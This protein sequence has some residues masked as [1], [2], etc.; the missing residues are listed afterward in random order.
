MKE[1]NNKRRITLR[2]FIIENKN[3]KN[4]TS[5]LQR[6]FKEK[7]DGSLVENRRMR[8]NSDD[9]KQ[10]EDILALYDVKSKNHTHGIM[11]R[12]IP[13]NGTQNIPDD[14]FKQEMIEVNELDSIKS[15]SANICK[16]HYYFMFNDSYLVTNLPYPKTIQRFQTYINWLLEKERDKKYFEFT[17]V[18]KSSPD[19]KLSDLKEV[20]VT[21]FMHINENKSLNNQKSKAVVETLK[22][23]SNEILKFIITDT[24]QLNQIDLEQIVSAQ[25]LIKFA[26]PKKADEEKY[27]K[28]LGALLKPISDTE[29]IVFTPKKGPKI[30]GKDLLYGKVV[31]IDLTESNKIS[32]QQLY[33]EMEIILN[34]LK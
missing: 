27:K 32:E 19:I 18:V 25:L 10:E 14:F 5:D 29:G 20:K 3:L 23:I 1:K 33:Q 17:P 30:S 8:L 15:D 13:A 16:D 11:M 34:E 26:K 9:P 22:N 7:I 31:E 2:A 6:I 24:A 12:I 4:S 28:T 21:D